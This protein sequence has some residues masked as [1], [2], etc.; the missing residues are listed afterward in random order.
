MRITEEQSR[1]LGICMVKGVSWYLVAREAQ[2]LDGLAR[3]WSGDI[4][5]SSPE[6][7][8]ARALIKE[9]AGELDRYTESAI[10][11]ADRAADGGA[12]LVTVLDKEY[13]ATLRLIFNLPPF[14]FV[15]GELRDTDLRSVAVVGTRQASEDGLRRA[16]R[17]SG[18]LTERQV[19]VVSGLARGIDTAAHTAAL[20][21]GGR[22]I[23]VVGTGILRCYPAENRGLADRIAESGAVVSQFWPDANGATY[24]FPRRNVTMSGIAQGT[25]VIEASSTSGAKMQARLAL[26]HGKRV[27]LLRSLTEAQPWAK[28]YVRTRGA[29]M[30]EDVDDV[31]N[32]LSSPD[33]IQAV[34]A[35]RAQLSLN[36]EDL[37][38]EE[39]SP[40]A[41]W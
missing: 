36:F 6:A 38:L 40:G 5:E 12:R 23:A 20:D 35:S 15:R 19:T 10:K 32:S 22:T 25:V 34:N 31:V 18:L 28:E 27:F 26:E 33:R 14:L 37:K 2:R 13:P 41:L 30:V 24:T 21:T 8:K 9:S 11:Q 39:P 3:L 1:L 17:M 16:R 7:T 4:V 29:L